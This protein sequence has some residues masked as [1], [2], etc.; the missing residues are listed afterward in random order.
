MCYKPLVKGSRKNKTTTFNFDF[1]QCAM[2]RYS[3]F[4]DFILGSSK[5]FVSSIIKMENIFSR[6]YPKDAVMLLQENFSTLLLHP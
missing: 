5:R 6:Q 1:V 4:D 3:L 2:M